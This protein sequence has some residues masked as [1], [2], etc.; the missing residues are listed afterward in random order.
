MT[1]IYL[2]MHKVSGKCYVGRDKYFPSRIGQHKRSKTGC[3]A[4]C[5]AIKKH[6]V[7]AFIYTAVQQVPDS[8][9]I[10]AEE[11]W[12]TYFEGYTKGYNL[13]PV[14]VGFESGENHPARSNTGKN[15][16]FY[17]KTHAVESKK[18]M[19]TNSPDYSGEKNPFYG[20]THTPETCRKISENHADVSGE[21]H[22][23]WNKSPTEE[24]RRKIS[25]TR[26][27]SG[28]SKGENNPSHRT[29]RDKRRGQLTLF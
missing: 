21:N 26:K 8:H 12:I 24:T 1:T 16:H 2:I 6:S 10:A 7:N 15:N 25:A 22:P 18:K 5:S 29:N 28:I 20:K 9:A 11:Y 17:G 4:I 27:Q 3:Q 19:S 13:T 23:R 14:G